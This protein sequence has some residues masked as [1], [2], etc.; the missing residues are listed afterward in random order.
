[1]GLK[2]YVISLVC[3]LSTGGINIGTRKFLSDAIRI[4]LATFYRNKRDYSLAG[5]LNAY[6]FCQSLFCSANNLSREQC[7]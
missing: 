4:L 1:M 6:S 2:D 3:P 5:C 7:I